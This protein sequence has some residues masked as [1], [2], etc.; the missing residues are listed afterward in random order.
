VS[1]KLS[2]K[3][4]IQS[5][6][7]ETKL[8]YVNSLAFFAVVVFTDVTMP[9]HTTAAVLLIFLLVARF[10]RYKNDARNYTKNAKSVV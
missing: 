9:R 4:C 8:W 1:A 3:E 6:A 7:R 5:Q 2:Q 10:A